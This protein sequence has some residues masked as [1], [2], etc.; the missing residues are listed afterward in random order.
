MCHLLKPF[1]R[2][3]LVKWGHGCDRGIVDPNF[4]KLFFER[5]K[6]ILIKRSDGYLAYTEGVKK[7]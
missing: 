4:I 6:L 2:Y 1:Y 7:Y 5:I 3:K